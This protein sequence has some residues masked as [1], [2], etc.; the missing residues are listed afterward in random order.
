M[1]HKLPSAKL[2]HLNQNLENIN[3][4]SFPQNKEKIL[5]NK[6]KVPYIIHLRQ[7]LNQKIF[8]ILLSHQNS[9]D[10]LS[11]CI[12]LKGKTCLVTLPNRKYSQRMKESKSEN[13][14]HST[15]RQ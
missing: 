9:L 15:K 7:P 4:G 1:V 6:I 2:E 11:N 5:Q 3:Q 10:T 13:V 8:F 14:L 12:N